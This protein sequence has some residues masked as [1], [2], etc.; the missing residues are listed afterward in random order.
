MDILSSQAGDTRFDIVQ[1]FLLR[2]RDLVSL[3]VQLH[4]TTFVMLTA[5]KLALVFEPA[6]KILM[7]DHS[8]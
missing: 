5:L 4:S 3:C 6:Y 8:N 2:N 7:R 1:H